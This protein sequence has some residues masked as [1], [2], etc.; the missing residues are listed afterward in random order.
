MLKKILLLV[1]PFF[2]FILLACDNRTN[3][4]EEEGSVSE[5]TYAPCTEKIYNMTCEEKCRN[6][7]Y[8]GGTCK[9]FSISPQG[10]EEKKRF[11]GNK[12]NAGEAS[13][14]YVPLCPN[15]IVGIEKICYCFASES[16]D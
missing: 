2:V 4:T 7:N 3:T 9:S 10:A 1:L 15:P 13:D 12:I 16:F 6:K 14:C 8:V 11:E 5:L